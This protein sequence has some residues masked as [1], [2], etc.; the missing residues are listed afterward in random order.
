[1]LLLHL[2]DL[3]VVLLVHLFEFSHHALTALVQG[4]LIIN[5]LW[6]GGEAYSPLRFQ[7]MLPSILDRTKLKITD[8]FS[9]GGGG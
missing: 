4:L 2:S 7:F 6:G 5:Q 8:F 9:K 3:L 1:M